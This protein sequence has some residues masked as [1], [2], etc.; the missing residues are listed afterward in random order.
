MLRVRCFDLCDSAVER[1]QLLTV[2]NGGLNIMPRLEF[3][4][5][6]QCDLAISLELEFTSE[7]FE[8]IASLHMISEDGHE[9]DISPLDVGNQLTPTDARP[10]KMKSVVYP[11]AISLQHLRLP[12]PGVYRIELR[13]GD[14]VVA[15]AR[16]A[17]VDGTKDE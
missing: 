16:F 3:P 15:V 1:G 9:L 14:E 12:A 8:L 13:S 7:T 11:Q 10:N 17:M 6:M 5:P 4:A 2:V